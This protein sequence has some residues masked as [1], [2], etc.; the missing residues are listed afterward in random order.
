[1]TPEI[2]ERHIIHAGYLTVERL[3]VR[4]ADGAEIWREVERHGDAAVVLPYDT[5]RRCALLVR[6][7]RAPAF[8]QSGAAEIVEAC[9][10][11]IEHEDAEAAA[12][13]EAMEELGVALASLQFVARVWASPG[14]STE[15]HT[16][17]LAPYR[18]TDRVAAGGGVAGE[19]EGIT[20]LEVPLADLAADA[21]HGR[22]D[23]GKL[24]TLL[25]ALRSRRPDLFEAS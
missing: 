8:D 5:E 4:L 21:D 9:A 15:R 13:R 11:M 25:L 18:A 2:L 7:F 12:R 19:H 22:I 16:L 14:V 24:L 3:R 17:F 20:V 10:G 6:L 23:D 1:V